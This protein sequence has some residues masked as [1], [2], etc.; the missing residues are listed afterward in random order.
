MSGENVGKAYRLCRKREI[1]RERQWRKSKRKGNIR[2]VVHL[3]DFGQAEAAEESP[4]WLSDNGAGVEAIVAACDGET[5]E[6]LLTPYARKTRNARDRLR[7]AHPELVEVFDL[8]VA[9]GGRGRADSIWALLLNR[10]APN[11]EAAK[12][13]YWTHLKKISLFFKVQ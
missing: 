13:R 3:V 11:W 5:P 9:N 12:K 8:A 4:S 10:R 1:D 7:R 6:A 2:N